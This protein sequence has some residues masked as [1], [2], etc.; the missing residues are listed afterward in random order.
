MNNDDDDG[1]TRMKNKKK[2]KKKERKIALSPY[3]IWSLVYASNRIRSVPI[4]VITSFE[5]AHFISFHHC[6]HCYVLCYNIR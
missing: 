2:K 3:L 5:T 4:F 6:H 1:Q